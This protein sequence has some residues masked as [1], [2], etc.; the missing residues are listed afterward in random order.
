MRKLI[1]AAMIAI[2]AASLGGCWWG[3]PPGG[4]GPGGPDHGP[5]G[6]GPG[7]RGG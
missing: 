7:P 3:P 1:M 4:P 2:T 6:P 5:G